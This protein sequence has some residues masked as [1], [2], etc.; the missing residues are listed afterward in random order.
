MGLKFEDRIV[1]FIDILNFRSLVEESAKS[2]DGDTSERL[3]RALTVI[4]KMASAMSSPPEDTNTTDPASLA[5]ANPH[6]QIFSD[7]IILSINPDTDSLNHLLRELTALFL[8]LMTLGIWIRGGLAHG[9]MSVKKATPCGPAMNVAY[10]TESMIAKNPR[11]AFA[12]DLVDWC[13]EQQ[14]GVLESSFVNRDKDGVY[15][16][17]PLKAVSDRALSHNVDPR[18]NASDIRQHLEYALLNV[19]DRPDVYAKISDLADR[20]NE[21]TDPRKGY[22]ENDERLFGYRTLEE[23]Y[24]DA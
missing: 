16:L 7:S 19:V 13:R 17:E 10:Y 3:E 21:W 12:K 15:V 1:V 23:V 20:W 14:N 11:I 8:T 24:L 2:P 22:F 5:S 4:E 9:K 18:E 6:L